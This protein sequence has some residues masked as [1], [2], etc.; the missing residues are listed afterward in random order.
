MDEIYGK[1][2][3]E[4]LA[5]LKSVVEL[6]RKNNVKVGLHGTS[7]WNSKYKDV[8]LL[9]VS[10]SGQHGSKNFSKAME[11]LKKQFSAKIVG[12][13]GN[14]AVGLDYD[15]EIGKLVLHVSYVPLL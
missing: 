7:L 12:Q 3:P 9:A 4:D 2:R 15:V 11:E 1:I 13:N 6:F 10:I 14:E 8:D 5:A